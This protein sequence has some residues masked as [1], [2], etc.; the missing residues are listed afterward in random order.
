MFNLLDY[1]ALVLPAGKVNKLVDVRKEDP[2]VSSYQS[3]N[4][5]DGYNW[6]LYDPGAMDGLPISI[7]LIGQR[8]EEEKML[9]AGKVVDGLLRGTNT[10]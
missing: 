4:D 7:Q 5:L 10:T 1:T 3:R 2:M 8:L 9:G 6:S